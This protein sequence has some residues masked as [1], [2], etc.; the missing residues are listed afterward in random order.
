[1]AALS[2]VL[3]IFVSV[4]LLLRLGALATWNAFL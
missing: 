2:L 1:M 4:E 3:G